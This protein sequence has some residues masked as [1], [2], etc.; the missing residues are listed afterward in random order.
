M[1]YSKFDVLG[2][3]YGPSNIALAV[4]FD[5][6]SEEERCF[7]LAFAEKDRNTAWHRGILLPWSLSQV[8]FMKDLATLRNPRSRFSFVNYLHENGRLDDFVNLGVFTPLRSEVSDYLSWAGRTVSKSQCHFEHE[9]VELSGVEAGGVV[10]SWKATFSNGA[11]FEA[12]DLV[13]SVGRDLNI[14]KEFKE[15]KDIPEKLVFHSENYL[16]GIAEHRGRKGLRVAVIGSAQSAAEVFRSVH[17]DL[18]DC[19]PTV[20]MRR[21]GFRYYDTSPFLN[22]LFQPAYVDRFYAMSEESRKDI[23]QQMHMANYGGLAPF[24]LNDLYRMQYL[25]RV[26]GKETSRIVTMTEIMSA[27]ADGD[28]VKLTLR[29]KTTNKLKDEVFDL[30][31]LGTGFANRLPLVLEGIDHLIPRTETG[32]HSLSR[33][34]QLGMAENVEA[35]LFLQGLAESTHGI[36]DTLLSNLA[37]R[38][39]RIA[40]SLAERKRGRDLQTAKKETVAAE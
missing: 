12:S 4:C 9:C 32:Q 6:L 34:Y 15:F 39:Q 40:R 1:T 7:S 16:S 17:D 11:E 21:A 24:L 10:R 30:V 27:K 19:R 35:G 14:P 37:D 22:E 2:L 31:I 3:G 23:L 33:D 13:V 36:A 18:P 26:E 8:S 25:Q 20:I 5:E 28:E 29:D 38:S